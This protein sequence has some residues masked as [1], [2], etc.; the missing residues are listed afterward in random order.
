MARP[1]KPIDLEAEAKRF[2]EAKKNTN[3][4]MLVV[5]PRIQLAGMAMA[6]LLIRHSGSVRREEIK[7]EAFEWADFMLEE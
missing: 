5:T 4:P 1:R 6:A 7:R 3:G 2:V